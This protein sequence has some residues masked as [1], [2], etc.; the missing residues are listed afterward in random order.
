MKKKKLNYKIYKKNHVKFKYLNHEYKINVIK[1]SI[2]LKRLQLVNQLEKEFLEK[3][4]NFNK[5]KKILASFRKGWENNLKKELRNYLMSNCSLSLNDPVFSDKEYHNTLFDFF[6]YRLKKHVKIN[7]SNIKKEVNK[8][9]KDINLPKMV[10]NKFEIL[11]K[12]YKTGD[13]LKDEKNIKFTFTEYNE[14]LNIKVNNIKFSLSVE[15][16]EKAKKRFNY[17]SGLDCEYL[18]VCLCLRYLIFGSISFLQ[19]ALHPTIFEQFKRKLNINIELFSSILNVYENNLYFSLFYDIE[20][21]F[22]SYGSFYYAKFISGNYEATIPSDETMNIISVKKILNSIKKSKLLFVIKIVGW[23]KEYEQFKS[24]YCLNNQ[25]IK[26]NL[27]LKHTN[28]KKNNLNSRPN[29]I[30]QENVYEDYKPYLLIKDSKYL[31]Y[32]KFLCTDEILWYDYRLKK[33]HFRGGS[34]FLYLSNYEID[35]NSIKTIKYS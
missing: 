17:N 28:Q 14:I 10:K 7:N 24:D 26:S 22:G 35:L 19:Q 16:Y 29:Q 34:I 32:Y 15:L 4:L 3:C 8:L 11:L 25:R 1:F 18:I 27:Y 31:K 33:E 23:G 21:Y 12:Y 2:E 30:L 20:K 5:N 6:Y 9:I 13:Y